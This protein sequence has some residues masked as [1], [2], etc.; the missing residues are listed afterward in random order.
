MFWSKLTL[1]LATLIDLNAAGTRRSLFEITRVP[2][3][4]PYCAEFTFVRTF[5]LIVDVN[6]L[7]SS[8]FS[9][10]LILT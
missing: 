3:E 5:K 1:S 8:K 7:S 10:L 2:Y 9:K 4:I 6:G